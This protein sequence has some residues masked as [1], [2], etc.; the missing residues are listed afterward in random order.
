MRVI[1]V[2]KPLVIWPHG[3][4][5]VRI[6]TVQLSTYKHKTLTQRKSMNFKYLEEVTPPGVHISK[7]YITTQN[8]QKWTSGV[9][10]MWACCAAC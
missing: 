7:D 10:D 8:T 9:L 1:T 2:R 6:N 3:P 5:G 4:S